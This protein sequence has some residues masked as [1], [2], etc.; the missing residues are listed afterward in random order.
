[1]LKSF[2]TPGV[3]LNYFGNITASCGAL[4]KFT[5][6]LLQSL[7]PVGGLYIHV[8]VHNGSSTFGLT[9]YTEGMQKEQIIKG[10]EVF[11]WCHGPFY[12]S[13]VFI[14]QKT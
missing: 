14:K 11:S 13:G 8:I 7:L 5:F 9:R 6:P 3:A 4:N 1:M 2:P 12:R 10:M